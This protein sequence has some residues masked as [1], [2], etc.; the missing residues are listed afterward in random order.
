MRFS[1]PNQNPH[2]PSPAPASSASGSSLPR[3]TVR[4][5]TRAGEREKSG[6]PLREGRRVAFR[7]PKSEEWILGL[8]KRA[9]TEGG[10]QMYVALR[11]VGGTL[12]LLYHI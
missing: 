1:S 12:F 8:V 3:I 2:S 5:P 10:K 4:L 11:D 6:A 7:P 9:F